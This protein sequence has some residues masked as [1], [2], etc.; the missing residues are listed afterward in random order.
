MD[1]V[2]PPPFE[3]DKLPA[4]ACEA[5]FFALTRCESAR[6]CC[7]SVAFNA[8]LGAP[9]L[10][11]CLDFTDEAAFGR[12][13]AEARKADRMNVLPWRTRCAITRR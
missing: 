11:A 7:V 5:V 1:S 3:L 13:K 4:P 6:A 8:S 2:A 10:W 9:H 12:G